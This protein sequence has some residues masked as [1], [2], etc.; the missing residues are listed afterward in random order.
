[1]RSHLRISSIFVYLAWLLTAFIPSAEL[2]AACCGSSETCDNGTCTKKQARVKMSAIVPEGDPLAIWTYTITF[3][4]MTGPVPG[5][6]QTVSGNFT[7]DGF[8]DGNGNRVPTAEFCAPI[9]KKIEVTVTPMQ[10]ATPPSVPEPVPP[11]TGGYGSGSGGNNGGSSSPTPED[12]PIITNESTFVSTGGATLKLEWC[13]TCGDSGSFEAHEGRNPAFTIGGASS[14][15]LG[16]AS[17]TLGSVSFRV[18]LGRAPDGKEIEMVI[19]EPSVAR[20]LYPAAVELPNVINRYQL[21]IWHWLQFRR[22]Y[23]D[24]LGSPVEVH[25]DADFT[26]GQHYVYRYFG[27]E[28]YQSLFQAMGI[29]PEPRLVTSN[30]GPQPLM[31]LNLIDGESRIYTP[32]PLATVIPNGYQ[33]FFVGTFP[34]FNPWSLHSAPKAFVPCPAAEYADSVLESNVYYSKTDRKFKQ[35][36]DAI[37]VPPGV[38]DDSETAGGPVTSD[39]SLD[40]YVRGHLKTLTPNV[41]IAHQDHLI[42]PDKDPIFTPDFSVNPWPATTNGPAPMLT[43]T[44]FGT[45]VTVGQTNSAV[46]VLAWEGFMFDKANGSTPGPIPGATYSVRRIMENGEP[47]VINGVAGQSLNAGPRVCLEMIPNVGSPG[48]E[49]RAYWR[50]NVTFSSTSYTLNTGPFAKW[51]F[52]NAGTIPAPQLL[53]REY[54]GD[55]SQVYASYLYQEDATATQKVWTLTQTHGARKEITTQSTAFSDG[56]ETEV[57]EVVDTSTNQTLSYRETQRSGARK[58]LVTKNG[59]GAEQLVSTYH[60]DAGSGKLTGIE[61]SDATF[62]KYFTYTDAQGLDWEATVRPGAQA[63]GYSEPNSIIHGAVTLSHTVKA[64]NGA[65]TETV[66]EFVEGQEMSITTTETTTTS[67]QH[68]AYRP[69]QPVSHVETVRR[70]TVP[71]AV[72]LVSFHES[73]TSQADPV[74]AGKAAMRQSEDGTTVIYHHYRGSWVSSTGEFVTDEDGPYTKTFEQHQGSGVIPY[75]TVNNVTVTDSEGRTVER[76]TCV[77]DT[78]GH[79]QR[80]SREVSFYQS[81][82]ELYGTSDV[83]PDG[84]FTATYTAAFDEGRKLSETDA[85]GARTEYS[86]FDTDGNPQTITVKGAPASIPLLA[87]PDQETTARYDVLGRQVWENRGGFARRTTFDT[88]GRVVAQEEGTSSG[89]VSLSN[90]RTTTTVYS[91]QNG[92]HLETVT[93]P[94]G[95]TRVSMSSAGGSLVSVWGTGVVAESHDYGS[96]FSIPGSDPVGNGVRPEAHWRGGVPSTRVSDGLGRTTAEAIISVTPEGGLTGAWRTFTYDGAGRVV[97]EFVGGQVVRSVDYTGNA[98][99]ETLYAAPNPNQVRVR[100]GTNILEDG[101]WWRVSV[102]NSGLTKER[103]SGFVAQSNNY[104]R[105]MSETLMMDN[106]NHVTRVCSYTDGHEQVTQVT[107]LSGVANPVVTVSYAGMTR[108][109][110]SPSATEPTIY[111]YD[112]LG[113]QT[114]VRSPE[115][116]VTTIGYDPVYGQAASIT[117]TG[118]DGASSVSTTAFYEPTS[119]WPGRVK[120]QTADGRTTRMDYTT[121]GETR[122]VWGATYPQSMEY[123]ESGQLW[124]LST[125]RAAAGTDLFLTE[126]SWPSSTGTADT[127]EWVYQWG[128]LVKKKHSDGNGP[129][130]TYDTRAQLHTRKWARGV[131]ATYGYDLAGQM[132]STSYSDGTPTV[133]AAYDALGRVTTVATSGGSGI[134]WESTLNRSFTYD[135]MTSQVTSE[136]ITSPPI[137]WSNFNYYPQTSQPTMGTINHSYSNGRRVWTGGYWFATLYSGYQNFSQTNTISPTTG[138]LGG[139]QMSRGGYFQGDFMQSSATYGYTPSTAYNTTVQRQ[140]G[141]ENTALVTT[142]KTPDGIGRLKT[143]DTGANGVSKYAMTYGYENGLRMTADTTLGKWHYA[144]NGR[145][146]LTGGIKKINGMVVPGYDFGYGFDAIGNRTTATATTAATMKANAHTST[147]TLTPNALNQITARTVPGELL[148]RGNIAGAGIPKAAYLMVNGG[149]PIDARPFGT[150]AN[151]PILNGDFAATAPLDNS[152]GIANA[153]VTVETTTRDPELIVSATRHATI[154]PAN[155][156]ITH[157][158]DGNLTSDG[159]W[160]YE[161][162]GENRLIKQ[163]AKAT[164]WPESPAVLEFAYDYMSR[165][166]NATVKDANGALLR[167]T[168]FLWDGWNILGQS[169]Y[170]P[171]PTGVITTDRTYV[172]G[173]DLSGSPQ[174]AGGVGCLLAVHTRATANGQYN[175]AQTLFPTYDGNGNIMSYLNAATGAVEQEEEY[176]PFGEN[177][178]PR[179]TNILRCPIGWSTKYTDEETGLVAYQLRYYNPTMGRWMSRDPMEEEGGENL[180]GFVGNDPTSRVDILGL[181]WSKP[182][183]QNGKWAECTGECGDTVKKLAESLKLSPVSY[184]KWLR[185]KTGKLPKD[186]N[187]PLSKD[188]AGSFEVPNTISVYTGESGISIA[189]RLM[190]TSASMFGKTYEKAGFR[191]VKNKKS[192]ASWMISLFKEEG[193]YGYVFGGHGRKATMNKGISASVGLSASSDELDFVNPAQ[194]SVPYSLAF[195]VAYACGSADEQYSPI[196]GRSGVV[197]SLINPQKWKSLVYKKGDFTGY[198]GDVYAWQLV[199]RQVSSRG[200]G[201]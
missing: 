119:S 144:Y 26:N 123:D 133:A 121:R 152:G 88:R 138:L 154:P 136:S 118:T 99:T 8:D 108:S 67:V 24:A 101:A 100:T 127:T 98:E 103:L 30:S 33:G 137:I 17:A 86:N 53:I 135:G 179:S 139:V 39:Q 10:G 91:V 105:M 18:N 23:G 197:E 196:F 167:R 90:V 68:L 194:A 15:S 199:S 155:E 182:D 176:G 29:A 32:R 84:N 124:K 37:S 107:E 116:A 72:P 163:T 12:P 117:T 38:V 183:R 143:I 85:T 42:T 180:Y 54:R 175:P 40:D 27:V 19:E 112:A 201:E 9:G 71:G 60:Y 104:G 77:R 178:R 149:A 44:H 190:I 195:M 169:D 126:T 5:A 31:P 56:A 122:H 159:L 111:G 83:D 168:R 134:A 185:P 110:R 43:V 171:T 73:Y 125:Y 89:N 141:G 47:A 191:I 4:D 102:S 70:S 115:G 62:T 79:N 14:A 93:M 177:L 142:T 184:E 106:A 160:T 114:E 172:W 41:G 57:F 189:A 164:P 157:D 165:R 51:V 129:E 95:A 78:D 52:T 174:G 162:D 28:G 48:Y 186:V 150:P 146:E 153:V 55:L 50:E 34:S 74:I 170:A 22:A 173:N 6:I 187:T 94:G 59:L 148:I 132:T 198:H 49:L 120:S 192:N 92:F 76:R 35:A 1:M 96:S 13:S 20:A 58:V 147:S 21:E 200:T 97:G 69:A 131:I 109:V 3:P 158:E 7:K 46:P 75:V 193:I 130:Y 113:R 166:I 45:P 151:G 140:A 188:E 87:I 61:N 2:K 25:D 161:W 36:A 66:R 80:I 81:S 156:V 65:E 16:H 181:A 63:L 128:L 145:G 64:N 11:T 82:G